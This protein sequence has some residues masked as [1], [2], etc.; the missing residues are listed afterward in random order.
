MNVVVNVPFLAFAAFTKVV[1]ILDAAAVTFEFALLN[2]LIKPVIPAS[3]SFVRAEPNDVI[4]LVSN[5]AI[6]FAIST[7]LFV[8]VI[9]LDNSPVSMLLI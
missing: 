1:S 6:P 2:A 8:C 7:N 3:P 5:P 9:T 4:P